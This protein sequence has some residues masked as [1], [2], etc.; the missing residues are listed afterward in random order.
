MRVLVYFTFL[1]LFA[2]CESNPND[3]YKEEINATKEQSTADSKLKS[4]RIIETKKLVAANFVKPKARLVIDTISEERT[5]VFSLIGKLPCLESA[6]I[7]TKQFKLEYLE[8]FENSSI[9]T[10]KTDGAIFCLNDLGSSKDVIAKLVYNRSEGGG[11]TDLLGLMIAKPSKRELHVLGLV[12]TQSDKGYHGVI[13]TR[14]EKDNIIIRRITETLGWPDPSDPEG[15]NQPKSITV[16][17]YKLTKDWN[18]EFL[19]EK[20]DNFNFEPYMKEE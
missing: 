4:D 2:S 20:I 5:K 13:E 1:I 16:Q 19:G 10:G 6:P 9:K 3:S 8:E 7:E 18:I 14:W 15:L 12:S 17:K 11:Q